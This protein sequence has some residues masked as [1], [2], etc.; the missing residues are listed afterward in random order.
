[1]TRVECRTR[2]EG[3]DVGQGGRGE[4]GRGR[5][6]IGKRRRE[7]SSGV[8]LC[9]KQSTTELAKAVPPTGPQG[10]GLQPPGAAR[11][12][13]STRVRT[14]R[15]WQAPAG[16]RIQVGDG[17]PDSCRQLLRGPVL[18]REVP[19]SR[20]YL[21]SVCT[22]THIASTT[23]PPSWRRSIQQPEFFEAYLPSPSSQVSTHATDVRSSFNAAHEL[24]D[25]TLGNE[26]S[27][28]GSA[29][30]GNFRSEEHGR[31]CPLP[32]SLPPSP[33]P[34]PASSNSP[35]ICT[36]SGV[37]MY[38]GTYTVRIITAYIPVPAQLS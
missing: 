3:W 21:E 35:S 19:A 18:A 5:A 30:Q 31:I 9:A 17:A 37:G 24:T 36:D 20:T 14:G 10:P 13:H 26:H 1:M 28:L 27:E 15:H 2:N 32:P 6:N 29:D 11:L 38:I 33:S 34:S 22:C 25:W 8:G 16:T 12:R 4:G 23:T 7:R